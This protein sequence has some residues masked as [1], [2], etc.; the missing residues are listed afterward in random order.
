MVVWWSDRSPFIFWTWGLR[1]HN[2]E[3][4]AA[5]RKRGRPPNPRR[6]SLHSKNSMTTDS[7]RSQSTQNSDSSSATEEETCF[8][9]RLLLPCSGC[10]E[11]AS[12]RRMVV[13]CDQCRKAYHQTCHF[14][15]ISQ[16]FVDDASKSWK[17]RDCVPQGSVRVSFDRCFFFNFV[18]K[19]LLLGERKREI[20]NK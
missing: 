8:S 3:G 18:G 1:R 19:I 17:C 6:G 2:M 9:L 20:I 4:V 10:G 7:P 15:R 5:K 11:N 12:E 14:P 13:V 16:L